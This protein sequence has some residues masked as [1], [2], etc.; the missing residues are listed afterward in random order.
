MIFKPLFNKAKIVCEKQKNKISK[1]I[2]GNNHHGNKNFSSTN[3]EFIRNPL[4]KKQGYEKF[5]QLKH[6]DSATTFEKSG[7]LK[8]TNWPK[9][10]ASKKKNELHILLTNKKTKTVNYH[11]LNVVITKKINNMENINEV[12]KYIY[13]NKDI[14]VPINYV[15]CIYKIYKLIKEK[16]YKIMN[17][18]YYI[19]NNLMKL[20]IDEFNKIVNLSETNEYSDLCNNILRKNTKK[21]Q[22]DSQNSNEENKLTKKNNPIEINI[23]NIKNNYNLCYTNYYSTNGFCLDYKNDIIQYIL[24]KINKNYFIKKLTYRHL[25]NLL[26]SLINIKYYNIPTYLIYIK[27]INNM[28]IYLSSQSISNIAYS[29]S[30]LFYFYS[31]DFTKYYENYI[32]KYYTFLNKYVGKNN[33]QNDHI[34]LMF[35]LLSRCMASKIVKHINVIHNNRYNIDRFYHGHLSNLKE[36]NE[37]EK[38]MNFLLINENKYEDQNII[39]SEEGKNI[40]KDIR[41][42]DKIFQE[43]FIFLWAISKIKINNIYV[44]LLHHLIYTNRVYFLLNLN[45][46]DI[47]NL[48]QS[49]N[50]YYPIKKLSQVYKSSLNYKIS[51]T[52]EN[53]FFSFNYDI[54]LKGALLLA[55]YNIKKFNYHH[56]SIILKS[57]QSIQSFFQTYKNK[58]EIHNYNG[59]NTF[60]NCINKKSYFP[61]DKEIQDHEISYEPF[62]KTYID[63]YQNYLK[64]TKTMDYKDCANKINDV[65]LK[66]IELVL[67]K[68]TKCIVNKLSK[69][70]K[71]ENNSLTRILNYSSKN[72][73][74][75]NLQNIST[76]L[77]S[78]AHI[79]DIYINS[80]LK[81]N[82]YDI[83]I[84]ILEDK[85]KYISIF[86]IKG[87]NLKNIDECL[88]KHYD[89]LICLS[90]INYALNKNNII[91]ECIIINSYLYL[92]N[93]YECFF[94]IYKNNKSILN[95]LNYVDKINERI[96][97]IYNW[98]IS[99]T[100]ISF[101]SLL[102][103]TN[104]N[105]LYI[106]YKMSLFNT[107]E[108]NSPFLNG[109]N[110]I[111]IFIYLKK[112][113]LPITLYNSI[114]MNQLRLTIKILINYYMLTKNDRNSNNHI[115]NMEKYHDDILTCM[116]SISLIITNLS[117]NLKNKQDNISN[118]SNKFHDYDPIQYIQFYIDMSTQLLKCYFYQLYRINGNS[119]KKYI[120]SNTKNEETIMK[121]YT[122]YLFV[123]QNTINN[124][125]FK[126]NRGFLVKFLNFNK[127]DKT[128]FEFLETFFSNFPKSYIISD[129]QDKISKSYEKE[130]DPN[131]NVNKIRDTMKK[132][133]ISNMYGINNYNYIPTENLGI[134]YLFQ[135]GIHKNELKMNRQIVEFFKN[136]N[137]DLSDIFH[138]EFCDF[139]KS[140]EQEIILIFKKVQSSK[141]HIKLYQ[142][143]KHVLKKKKNNNNNNNNNLDNKEKFLDEDNNFE[144]I[145]NEYIIKKD[146]FF[147][148][149]DIYD[150]LTNTIFE[151]NGNSHYTKQYISTNI[152][153]NS[154][155][156]YNYKSY[157]IFKH[158]ILNKYYNIVHLPLHDTKLCK[159]IISEYYR[160]KIL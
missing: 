89:N 151:I 75:L 11:E 76:Y 108:V 156:F 62:H 125:T 111:N 61:E 32:F 42:K 104:Y 114:T 149:V 92:Y 99:H 102:N 157:Y 137:L 159:Q 83:I 54:Y 132:W 36:L 145:K 105:Y 39:D 65:N 72:L 146:N 144:H 41:K 80:E 139:I 100:N 23:N 138:K 53:N 58:E 71:N 97:S 143:I 45:E 107:I 147:F 50:I 91:N 90:N 101:M 135:K 126:Y 2:V 133:E 86:D 152:H 34:N 44:D 130:Q 56:Y 57:I 150:E 8:A 142:Y 106:L 123:K 110:G 38:K 63:N 64:T 3:D 55:I 37:K 127:I 17:Y 16:D 160:E 81:T 158:L 103:L 15:V 154:R 96:L 67:S 109:K 121:F 116:Y 47:C 48:I 77:Y 141:S 73:S 33:I 153:N 20:N 9:K 7:I 115:Y 22:N 35:L 98:T 46:K 148:I 27:H 85:I 131:L 40:S 19:N 78:L 70:L 30:Q 74:F 82:L 51:I 14:L 129:T 124:S 119:I 29:Y 79:S 13:Y 84:K 18:S 88:Q 26:Y 94:K 59:I 60:G 66:G 21:Y 95:F 122:F 25:T 134:F 113:L 24:E 69:K 87:I 10:K 28:Y 49:L 31:I 4:K 93:F 136:H 112:M 128:E 118:I 117:H 120:L 155:F 68:L 140:I 1:S 5:I 6:S 43:L 12:Y 52:N